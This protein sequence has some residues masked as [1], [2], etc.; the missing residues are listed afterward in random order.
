M[1]R[2]QGMAFGEPSPGDGRSTAPRPCRSPP[3]SAWCCSPGSICRRRWSPGSST[4]RRCCAEG[5]RHDDGQT[6]ATDG[7]AWREATSGSRPARRGWSACGATARTRAWRCRRTRPELDVLPLRRLDGAFPVGRRGA[8]RRR[9]AWSG[10]SAISSADRATARRTR[11]PGSIMAVGR[12]A[13]RSARRPARRRRPERYAFLAAEGVGLHQIPVGPVHAGIIEPGH[14]RFHASGETVVRLEE[15]LG[16]VHKGVERLMAGA[17]LERGAELA[18]RVSGDST[19]AYQFAFARAA[20]AALGIVAPPRARV[21]AR[22]DGRAGAAR[23]S[24]RRHRRDLQRRLV[25][26]DARALRHPARAGAARRR[27]RFRPS[28]DDGCV[29]PGGVA[30]DLTPT[31]RAAFRALIGDDPRRLS[32]PGQAL[33]QH[34]LAAGPH[35]AAP[36]VLDRR[37]G[38]AIRLRRLHRPRLGPRLRRA[39]RLPYSPYDELRF[40]VPLLARG[41]RQRAG[42]DSHPRGRAEPALIDQILDRAARRSDPRRSSSRAGRAGEG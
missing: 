16:Y 17:D 19:V 33:R 10:R 5:S 39:A 20:E 2:L 31:A 42:L 29:V 37:A 25:L 4:S 41:R 38:A 8:S 3:I 32:A 28:A 15:R 6:N 27:R 24:P 1:L 11:G 12:S 14:F 30:V 7:A 22:A 40:E 9:S 34:R 36:G 26:A 13:I 18:G 21:A 35:G 23:Q